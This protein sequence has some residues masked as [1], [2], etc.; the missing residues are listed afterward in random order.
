M[1]LEDRYDELSDELKEKAAACT[2]A[3]ELLKLAEDNMIALSDEEIEA[4][5][6]GKLWGSS[7][8]WADCDKAQNS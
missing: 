4:V 1:S 8:N 3:D 6:G 2:S 5:S 7:D